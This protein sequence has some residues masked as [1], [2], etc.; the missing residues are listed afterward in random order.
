MEANTVTLT[1][2][3]YHSLKEFK[4]EME[5]NN[6][7]RL[8]GGSWANSYHFIYKEQAFKEAEEV[9]ENL[10]K[11]NEYLRQTNHQLM[12]PP[13][14]QEKEITLSDVKKM[15]IWEFLKWKRK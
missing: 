8:Y 3:D 1:L 6:V 12:Y 10:R 2:S 15:S 14:P 7:A 11:E 4:E 13:Q 5:K 9:N